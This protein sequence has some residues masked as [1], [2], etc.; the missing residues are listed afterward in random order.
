MAASK[1]TVVIFIIILA[2]LFT[3]LYSVSQILTP[4]AIGLLLAYF[5]SPI[6]DK[7][8]RFK[9]GRSLSSVLVLS[10]ILIVIV[11][12]SVTVI[13]L[14]YNQISLLAYAAIERKDDLNQ[15]V[16]S[17]IGRFHL[18]PTLMESLQSSFSDLGSSILGVFGNF[19]SRAVE[20]SIAAVNVIALVFV[21]PIV[22]YYFLVDW[23]RLVAVIDSLIPRKM[24]ERYLA[25]K[26]DIDYALS[27][28]IRGQSLVCLIMG[29]YYAMGLTI[30]GTESALA[31]GFIAGLLTF[32]PFVGALFSVSL[33]CLIIA[34][35][36]S[37]LTKVFMVIALFAFGNFIENNFIVPKFIG[38]RLHL[39]PV[40]VIFGLLA[41]GTLLGFIGI[42][43]ALPLTA[44]IAV[45]IR[46]LLK[47]YKNSSIYS[48]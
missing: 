42:L 45:V 8:E 12:F 18:Y 4:F 35:Q 48:S 24:L 19:I 29:I 28:F 2:A 3:L 16:T 14:L 17:L 9:I 30:I 1:R 37:S 34:V 10:G 36:Y 43:I 23:P 39:H 22:L 44:V 21:T 40:W 15:F 31:L 26:K 6:V 27:N 11:V 38:S 41:G 25:L 13:P 33:T 20:S 7:L 47:D 32:I 5:C 46:Y